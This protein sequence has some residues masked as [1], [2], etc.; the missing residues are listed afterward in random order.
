MRTRCNVKPPCYLHG[1]VEEFWE[2]W[3]LARDGHEDEFLDLFVSWV[4]GG[5]LFVSDE[6]MPFYVFGCW[7]GAAFYSHLWMTGKL[8]KNGSFRR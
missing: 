4:S 2:W 5:V 3:L 1:T 7:Q 6:N 8:D